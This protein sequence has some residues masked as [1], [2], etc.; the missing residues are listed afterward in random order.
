[1]AKKSSFWKWLDPY[2]YLDLFLVNV[3]GDAKDTKTKIIHWIFYIA[4]SFLLAYLIYLLF[5]LIL[6]VSMPFATVVSGSMEPVLHRGDIVILGSPKSLNAI[7]VDFNEDIRNRNLNEYIKFNYVVNNY[8]LEQV[9]SL[10]IGNNVVDISQIY[11]NDVVVYYSNLT[12]KPIIHRIVVQINANDGNFILTKGDNFKTNRTVDQDC[13]IDKYGDVSNCLHV[14]A[15]PED[16][17][18]GKKIGKIPYLGYIKL[19][20][21]GN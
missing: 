19:F 12:K 8:G 5:S 16:L 6:G 14:Y 9:D 20:L 18:V 10:V 21:F 2:Y 7:V 1:M 17:V 4:Y 13:I 15:I 11:D 3:F